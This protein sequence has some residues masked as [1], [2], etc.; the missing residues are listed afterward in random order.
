MSNE[1]YDDARSN[2]F[3]PK[4]D[5]YNNFMNRLEEFSDEGLFGEDRLEDLLEKKSSFLRGNSVMGDTFLK[6]NTSQSSPNRHKQAFN[7]SI[8]V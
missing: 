8:F 4:N 7:N 1:D 3:T 6:G 5:D 2:F